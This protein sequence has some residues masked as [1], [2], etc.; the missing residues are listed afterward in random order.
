MPRLGGGATVCH[1]VDMRLTTR[2]A[3]L[4]HS[5]DRFGQ[6][7][8]GQIWTA[9]FPGLKSKKSWEDVYT[10]LERQKFIA[11]MGR[12]MLRGD[13]KGSAPLV[14]QLDVEGLRFLG[15]R[16][17]LRR[18]YAAVSEH[19]LRV[20][21]AF[22]SLCA[23]E[24]AGKLKIL[25]YFTEP[26]CH[27]K[28]AGVTVR[29]DLYVVIRIGEEEPIALWLEIDRDKENRPEIQRKVRDY[30]TVLK[31][32]QEVQKELGYVPNVL[33]LADT[34]IGRFNLESYLRNKTEGFESYFGVDDL[35]G[36]AGRFI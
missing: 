28:L 16:G 32:W 12:R 24:D 26:D 4:L 21:D 19:R 7:D 36:W 6:L 23:E 20:A 33:F 9:H 13:A 3:D 34:E 22:L 35:D 29:P 11:R 5:L 27:M 17:T 31:A 2:D 1:D 10:R 15:K 14:W 25:G 8:S 18:R 30:M